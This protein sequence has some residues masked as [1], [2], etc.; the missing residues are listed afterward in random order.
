[1]VVNEDGDAYLQIYAWDPSDRRKAGVFL[2]LGESGYRELKA[3][4]EKAKQ[5]IEKLR[6]ANR[7][8]RM[9]VF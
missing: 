9:R 7:M 8:Q 1:M 4:M 3:V 6:D 2:S 5:T